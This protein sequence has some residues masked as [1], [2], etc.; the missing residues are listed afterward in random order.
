ME[1][2]ENSS[3]RL[4]ILMDKMNLEQADIVKRTGLTKSAV[5]QYVNGKRE[6]R[7]DAIS[8]I[9]DA[10]SLNPTWFMGY[11]APMFA[12]ASTNSI[13][14]QNKNISYDELK[15]LEFWNNATPAAKES[16]MILL[17]NSQKESPSK[18]SREA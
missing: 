17:E 12:S 5:S 6:P 9:C 16:V 10:Y 13:I 2:R 1:K 15:L 7:Q 8:I 4:R 3:Q 18:L 11:D 14:G